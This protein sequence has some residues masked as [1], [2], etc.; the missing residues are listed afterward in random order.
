MLLAKLTIFLAGLDL[1][2]ISS[3]F[4][5][6][7]IPLKIYFPQPW[8]AYSPRAKENGTTSKPQL[9]Q[10]TW[11]LLSAPTCYMCRAAPHT[12]EAV[13]PFRVHPLKPRRLLPFS[14]LFLALLEHVLRAHAKPSRL[15]PESTKAVE[16]VS[17]G[18]PLGHVSG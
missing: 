14:S 7:K 15:S 3:S 10:Q 13:A 17:H 12:C 18:S 4:P 8:L 16:I 1:E 9:P 11:K 6:Y 5:T 2:Q